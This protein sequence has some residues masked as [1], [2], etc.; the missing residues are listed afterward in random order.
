MPS[1]YVGFHSKLERGSGKNIEIHL[2]QENHN[3]DHKKAIKFMGANKTDR[4][5]E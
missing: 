4:A 2:L 5:I 1:V 3:K